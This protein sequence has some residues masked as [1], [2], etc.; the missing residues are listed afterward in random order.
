MDIGPRDTLTPVIVKLKAPDINVLTEFEAKR[1]EAIAKLRNDA[2]HGG[3]FAYSEKDVDAA[4]KEVE[5]I[6]SKLLGPA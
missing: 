1:L 5:S 6:L 4:L 3:D 2:A